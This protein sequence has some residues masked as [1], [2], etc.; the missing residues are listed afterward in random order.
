LIYQ[1]WCKLMKQLA[2]SLQMSTCIRLDRST[3]SK[4]D[5]RIRADASW[6]NQAWCN[7]ISADLMQVDEL[8][9]SVRRFASLSLKY[10]LPLR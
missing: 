2:S 8:V 3:C 4:S 5:E 6:E 1:T 10:K 9:Y 7:L